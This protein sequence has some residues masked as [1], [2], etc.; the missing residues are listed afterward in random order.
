MAI[1]LL[2]NN[3]TL[4]IKRH[5]RSCSC[6]L[7]P[8]VHPLLGNESIQFMQ[9]KQTIVIIGA[10]CT[11]KAIAKVLVPGNFQLLLCDKEYSNA[12]L[13]AGELQQTAHNSTIEAMECTFD[14]AWEADLVVLAVQEEEQLAVASIIKDVV[15]QKILV[16]S[17]Q[18]ADCA[19][20]KQAAHGN[21]KEALQSLLPHTK[22]V[23]VTTG[24]GLNNESSFNLDEGVVLT[25]DDEKA[26]EE[27]AGILSAAGILI[28]KRHQ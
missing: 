10:G 16:S 18:P 3:F 19:D 27:V 11:G 25:G 7:K 14:S 23:R 1:V 8:A 24:E 26:I 20:A 28:K 15:N 17:V 22:V 21:C 9:T 2:C 4:S 12:V 5:L 13:L 6:P